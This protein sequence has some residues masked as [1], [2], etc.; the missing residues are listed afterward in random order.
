MKIG[1]EGGSKMKR[2][3]RKRVE[4]GGRERNKEEER[5]K[6][7]KTEEERRRGSENVE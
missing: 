5:G 7:R 3:E 1:K 2:I 6:E 4:K